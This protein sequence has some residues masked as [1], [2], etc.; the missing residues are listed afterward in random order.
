MSIY[1]RKG[2]R[3]TTSLLGGK[4]VK[5]NNSII[6]VL[7]S[8][9]ELNAAL[10]LSI[11]LLPT[12]KYFKLIAE[13][14]AIQNNLFCLGSNIANPTGV[15]KIINK[16]PYA[17][18]IIP[19][20]PTQKDIDNLENAIDSYDKKLKP[21]HFFIFPGG[22]K[23][24]AALHFSRAICRRVERVVVTLAI[25]KHTHLKYLNRLS[26]YLFIVARFVN[27]KSKTKETVWKP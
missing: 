1:T 9:D 18:I 14:T 4:R 21:L 8:I 22:H 23:A 13:L 11:S 2:D 5:K 3:G 20:K 27:L 15:K 7:G 6:E 10:G 12:K 26:D 17:P 19:Q 16:P 24:A 25:A